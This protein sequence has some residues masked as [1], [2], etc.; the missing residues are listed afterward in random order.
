[1]AYAVNV[2]LRADSS[3]QRVTP[4]ITV[5]RRDGYTI[6]AFEETPGEPPG[7]VPPPIDRTHLRRDPARGG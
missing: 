5:T 1:M 4:N 2:M 3:P 7:D 6:I